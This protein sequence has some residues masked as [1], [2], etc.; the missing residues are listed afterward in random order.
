MDIIIII[1]LA[2]I[3]GQILMLGKMVWDIAKKVGVE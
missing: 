3:A 1:M 2:L